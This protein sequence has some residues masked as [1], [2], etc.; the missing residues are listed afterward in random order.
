MD[1]E[2]PE[3]AYPEP[4][5][6]IINPYPEY[7]TFDPS[8]G[9]QQSSAPP[10]HEGFITREDILQDFDDDPERDPRALNTKYNLHGIL[11]HS[12][13]RDPYV[14]DDYDNEDAFYLSLIH[15]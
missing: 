8:L 3:S 13:S 9:W 10:V 6:T 12:T 4:T 2:Q 14:D 11:H 7:A 15:I 5:P 1:R